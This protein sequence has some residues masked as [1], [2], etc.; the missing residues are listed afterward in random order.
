MFS[1]ELYLFI[2]EISDLTLS[3]QEVNKKSASLNIN[4][5]CLSEKISRTWL[6]GLTMCV[7]QKGETLHDKVKQF[8]STRLFKVFRV[9]RNIL[10]KVIKHGMQFFLHVFL[11]RYITISPTL[12]YQGAVCSLLTSHEATISPLTSFNLVFFAFLSYFCFWYEVFE[13]LK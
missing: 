6:W 4:N 9:L 5:A 11:R 2:F 12:L 13:D 7:S 3:L 1:L 10:K 8:F